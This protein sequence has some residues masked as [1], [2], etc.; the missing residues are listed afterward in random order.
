[1]GHGG[2]P[3]LVYKLQVKYR[4]WKAPDE[5][6]AQTRLIMLGERL[7][8]LLQPVKGM[9]DFPLQVSAEPRSLLFRVRDRCAE[10]CHCIRMK[11]DRLHENWARSSANTWA[12]GIPTTLP[13]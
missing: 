3:N 11:N 13:L 8:R 1:M 5:T 7:R 6:L 9:L 10:F 2:N 12:A 4:V